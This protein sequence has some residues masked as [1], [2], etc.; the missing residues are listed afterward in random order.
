[1]NY[2][3]ADNYRG[4]SKTLIPIVSVNFLVGENSTGKTSI[5]GLIKL[6]STPSFALS[7]SIDFKGVDL[8]IFKDIVS[9]AAKNK[10]K[11]TI[12]L[13]YKNQEE[14]NSLNALIMTFRE[15][16]GVPKIAS[17]LSYRKN[18]EVFIKY[19][20]NMKAKYKYKVIE[21]KFNEKNV[22]NTAIDEW[23]SAHHNDNSGYQNLNPK[24]S[25]F[26]LAPAIF[27]INYIE[28]QALGESEQSFS[29]HFDSP[30]TDLDWLAPIRSKPRKTYDDFTLDFSPEGDHIPYLIK[31]KL[32]GKSESEEF[33]NFISKIGNQSGLFKSL[34]IKN[35]ASGT[36]APF[37]L[38]V[39]LDKHPL[40]ISSVG[41]GVSQA[42]PIITEMFTRPHQ[43]WLAIQQPEVHLHPRAQAAIGEACFEMAAE[44]GK[45]FIIETHSDYT[46]DRFRIKLRE[47]KKKPQ[48]QILYFERTE[49]GNKV[50]PISIDESGELD[51]DQ[52]NSYRDFF[53]KEDMALLGL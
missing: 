25:F 22:S 42:L 17:I 21:N 32:D 3:Y 52:P 12:G 20:L 41:Y 53:L 38:D 40:K 48:S 2:I 6:I 4:F 44:R 7:Q 27:L 33:K 24:H 26:N 11:F 9:I 39:I 23:V 36:A 1:M 49:S 46:I 28:S 19:S 10:R 51:P 35:Y 47:S 14:K 29:A 8:G 31:K 45:K 16:D 34:A 18:V 13:V 43:S 15:S 50:T 5:L 30:I 37:E